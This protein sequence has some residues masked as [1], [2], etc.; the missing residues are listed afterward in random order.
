MNAVDLGPRLLAERSTNFNYKS[1]SFGD[2][3]HHIVFRM[4]A[5]VK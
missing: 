3:G 1:R 2:G 4:N 5:S